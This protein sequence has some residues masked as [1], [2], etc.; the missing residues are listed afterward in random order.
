MQINSIFECKS[1]WKTHW[2]PTCLILTTVTFL[3]MWHS[4]QC[5]HLAAGEKE[6]LSTWWCRWS[7]NQGRWGYPVKCPSC[8]RCMPHPWHLSWIHHTLLSSP[9]SPKHEEFLW[10]QQGHDIGNEMP[11]LSLG[12]SKLWQEL[13]I[14]HLISLM[15]LWESRGWNDLH[16][17]VGL[18]LTLFGN[19]ENK[20]L[21]LLLGGN[22]ENRVLSLLLG[23]LE[24]GAFCGT[25]S[26]WG[27]CPP[28]HSL[29][30]FK[31]WDVNC[32]NPCSRLSV[33]E[34]PW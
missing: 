28:E 33:R 26:L 11:W 1:R 2:I 3:G 32:K 29:L 24:R 23:S 31:L 22:T 10:R 6:Q 20:V 17:D 4:Q 9:S 19:M 21:S 8:S 14:F 15:D 18:L 7:I 12:K 25:G 30:L 13:Q 5:L 16:R 34:I 27:Q